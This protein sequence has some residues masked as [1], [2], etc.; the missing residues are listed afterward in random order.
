MGERYTYTKSHLIIQ[1]KIINL[2]NVRNAM[3]AKLGQLSK[4][5]SSSI[6]E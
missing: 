2:P 5:V 4:I 1:R 3:E 6:S